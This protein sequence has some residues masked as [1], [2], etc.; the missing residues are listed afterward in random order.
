MT[1]FFDPRNYEFL[2]EKIKGAEHLPQSYLKYTPSGHYLFY[3]N[4]A[5]QKGYLLNTEGQVVN[6]LHEP[7]TSQ[8][9]EAT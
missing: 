3:I 6:E 1:A 7:Y 4:E 5:R 9:A 2:K 8:M